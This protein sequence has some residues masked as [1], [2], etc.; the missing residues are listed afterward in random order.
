MNGLKLDSKW[1]WRSRAPRPEAFDSRVTRHRRRL[2]TGRPADDDHIECLI[3]LGDHLRA[4]SLLL[5]IRP[6]EG[7]STALC[8]C[9]MF[10]SRSSD[11]ISGWKSRS[12]SRW[13]RD[14]PRRRAVRVRLCRR[15]PTPD[16][17]TIALDRDIEKIGLHLHQKIT[18]GGP[19][20][21]SELGQRDT[22]IVG[23]GVQKIRR[24][25]RE[26]FKR[27]ACDVPSTGAPGDPVD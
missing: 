12:I 11:D 26:R 5:V 1:P 10:R 20:I 17:R 27:R 3:Q 8:H 15:R 25:V 6:V 19:T 22:G 14:S 23:H 21:H 24:L 16:S 9:A 2:E 4:S 7:P 13:T 18:D